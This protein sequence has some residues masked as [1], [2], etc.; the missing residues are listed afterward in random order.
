MWEEQLKV[1]IQAGVKA[2]KPILEVYNSPFD[3]EIKDDQSPVTLADKTA[4]YI[5]RKYLFDKFPNYAFLTE[6]SFDDKSR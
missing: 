6:E 4:D 5:I 1:A 3:V 2:V